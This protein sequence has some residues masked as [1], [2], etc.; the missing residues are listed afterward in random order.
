MVAAVEEGYPQA[1][2]A[3]AAYASSATFERG[4]RVMVGVNAFVQ[5]D[6]E[7]P[8]IHRADPA[9]EA[10]PGDA[11]ARPAR[12]ARRGARHAAALDAPARGLRRRTTT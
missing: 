2:I 4:E 12:R 1:E 9:A 5:R 11:R 8:V 10:A 7:E 3:D 6:E